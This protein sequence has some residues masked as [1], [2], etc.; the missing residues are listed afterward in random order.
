MITLPPGEPATSFK[1][2]RLPSALRSN[3]STG[4]IELRGRLRGSTR[5]AT[6]LP[7]CSGTNEKSVNWLLRMKPLTIRWEPKMVSI[8]VVIATA[9]PRP[10]TTDRCE[11]DGN[12]GDWSSARASLMP[13]GLPGC[14]TPVASG[15]ISR[16]RA[17]R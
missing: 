2:P 5:L 12:S 16:A 15:P 13:G 8:E 14:A 1:G 9:L 10:S 6:G 4:D 11:V 3:T 7:S 17:T